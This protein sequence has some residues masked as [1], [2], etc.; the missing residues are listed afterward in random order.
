VVPCRY[1]RHGHTPT[2]STSRPRPADGAAAGTTAPPA[3]WWTAA[4]HAHDTST[5]GAEN[6]SDAG[7]FN[8][9]KYIDVLLEVLNFIQLIIRYPMSMDNWMWINLERVLNG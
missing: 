3:S 8:S 6:A 1:D 7:G 2:A 9:W 5:N 4:P